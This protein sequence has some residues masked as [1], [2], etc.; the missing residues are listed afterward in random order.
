VVEAGACLYYGSIVL[1]AVAALFGIAVL[2][3]A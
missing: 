3:F 2:L 1:C